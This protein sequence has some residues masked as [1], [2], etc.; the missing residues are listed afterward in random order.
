[1]LA[2]AWWLEDP[3]FNLFGEYWRGKHSIN[4]AL[5]KAK[6]FGER[7]EPIFKTA[8]ARAKIDISDRTFFISDEGSLGICPANTRAA[9]IVVARDGAGNPIVVRLKS[10]INDTGSRA[11]QMQQQSAYEL[12]GYCYLHGHM[13]AEIMEDPTWNDV[14]HADPLDTSPRSSN[15]CKR[16]RGSYGRRYYNL[17]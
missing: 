15:F 2:F 5:S 13:H 1:M 12:V 6:A 17:V 14:L 10:N 8:I 9:D 4:R 11:E 7:S 16:I 3:N